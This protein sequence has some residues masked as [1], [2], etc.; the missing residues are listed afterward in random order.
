MVQ[1]KEIFLYN[2]EWIILTLKHSLQDQYVQ[3]WRE[4]A[5]HSG[6]GDLYVLIKYNFG[7]ENYLI[8]QRKEVS[9][10]ITYMR[11][12]NYKLPIETGRYLDIERSDRICQDN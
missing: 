1:Q 10:Y 11:T 6:K 8:K 3:K 12:S 2:H 7:L 9:R 4:M 5:N